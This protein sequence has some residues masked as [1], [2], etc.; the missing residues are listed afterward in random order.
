VSAVAALAPLVLLI[1][2]GELDDLAI[3]LN[4]LEVA[5]IHLRRVP[6]SDEVVAPRKLLITTLARALELPPRL[7]HERR[8]NG[9]IRIA[10]PGDEEHDDA[11]KLREIGFDFMMRQA[12][13]RELVRLF[14][15]RWLYGCDEESSPSSAS[16]TPVLVERRRHPR[17]PFPRR[18]VAL[19]EEAARVVIACNLSRG[20]LFVEPIPGVSLHEEFRLALYGAQREE[21][22]LVRAQVVR[23]EGKQGIALRFVGLDP[24]ATQKVEKLIAALP[25]TE[26][27]RD[28]RCGGH[29]SRIVSK[30][31][32]G[33]LLS[34]TVRRP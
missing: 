26:S 17:G 34:R 28:D 14:L 33:A 24:Y 21:P 29:G 19:H 3:A 12:L 10:V 27:L 9:P 22:I 32:G 31:V 8:P 25:A 11:R 15:L 2:D 13:P 30:I 23:D 20:G 1:D 16:V 6:V 18:V 4:E 7:T 5:S